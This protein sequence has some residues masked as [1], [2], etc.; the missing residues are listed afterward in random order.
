MPKKIVGKNQFVGSIDIS[1]IKFLVP[2]VFGKD[3][4]GVNSLLVPKLSYHDEKITSDSAV[5]F[6]SAEG[7]PVHNFVDGTVNTTSVDINSRKKSDT[8]NIHPMIISHVILCFTAW[9]FC[10]PLA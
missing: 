10:G 1:I 7:G 3:L 5:S 4:L 6:T 9:G 8:N 2:S